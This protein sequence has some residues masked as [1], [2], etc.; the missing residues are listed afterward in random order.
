MGLM[1]DS[2]IMVIKTDK[3]N[4]ISLMGWDMLGHTKIMWNRGKGLFSDKKIL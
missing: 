4:L 3:D 2:S 1:K